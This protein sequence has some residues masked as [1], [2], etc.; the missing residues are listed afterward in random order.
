MAETKGLM[1]LES[2]DSCSS[3]EDTANGSSKLKEHVI[4]FG[5]VGDVMISRV[6]KGQE[7][8]PYPIS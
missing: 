7:N 5:L 8:S 3:F 6:Q 1:C 4:V 2:P